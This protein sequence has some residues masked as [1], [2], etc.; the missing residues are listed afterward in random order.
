VL[1]RINCREATRL[2]SVSRERDLRLTESMAL[3][4]HLAVCQMCRN[5]DSQLRFIHK[6]ASRFRGGDD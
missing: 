3:K 4:L 5:F 2:L 6:A 1:G